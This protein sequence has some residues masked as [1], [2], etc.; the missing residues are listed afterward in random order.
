ML[1]LYQFFTTI[2]LFIF[3][4]LYLNKN[5]GMTVLQN[6]LVRLSQVK[7]INANMIAH[8]NK[9]SQNNELKEL[10]P[11][12]LFLKNQKKRFLNAAIYEVDRLKNEHPNTAILA[13]NDF[14]FNF[15]V[16]IINSKNIDAYLLR[17]IA[18]EQDFIGF[19]LKII[20][21]LNPEG[22]VYHRLVN[23][24]D[25]MRSSLTM[26]ERNVTHQQQLLI[27]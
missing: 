20:S 4:T 26:L 24:I 22:A 10:A 19:Y 1:I 13:T 15:V 25:E 7:E 17:L 12:L 14:K 6:C 18:T 8:Y 5:N 11:S 2:V 16:P 21:E 9:L 27:A 23:H 3:L